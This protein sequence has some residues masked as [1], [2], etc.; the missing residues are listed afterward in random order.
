MP[1][2]PRSFCL[3]SCM[4]DN[5]KRPRF[6]NLLDIRLPVSGVVSILHR[7][8]GIAL[9]MLVPFALYLLDQ[10]LDSEQGYRHAAAMLSDPIAKTLTVI[11]AW[12]LIHHF[13]AG[14]RH[15]FLDLDVGVGRDASRQSAWFV[16]ALGLPA[17]IAGAVWLW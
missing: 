4:P 6:L 17:W 11:G 9:A 7:I 16:L 8:S 5:K 3:I 15:L 2:A 10:S 14:V 12:F 13:L 1:C